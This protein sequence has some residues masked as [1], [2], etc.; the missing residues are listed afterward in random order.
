MLNLGRD[1]R[2]Q[3]NSCSCNCNNLLPVAILYLVGAHGF[4]NKS[5]QSTGWN[6]ERNESYCHWMMGPT[7]VPCKVWTNTCRKTPLHCG[8]LG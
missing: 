2:A 4:P 1:S 6:S 7:T 5:T 3:P 8:T